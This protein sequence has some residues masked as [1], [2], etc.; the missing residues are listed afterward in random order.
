MHIPVT[1]ETIQKHSIITRLHTNIPVP[2][3]YNFY[4]CFSR[5][6]LLKIIARADDILWKSKACFIHYS[7]ST[8]SNILSNEIH[9]YSSFCI[10]HCALQEYLLFK[11]RESFEAFVRI[12]V[13]VLKSCLLRFG[14]GKMYSCV[15][16]I[17]INITKWTKCQIRAQKRYKVRCKNKFLL[18]YENASHPVHLLN[19]I[20]Q[21]SVFHYYNW[22]V[23]GQKML[24]RLPIVLISCCRVRVFRRPPPITRS[25]S[26]C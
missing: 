9:S 1:I 7:R 23:G 21:D 24:H 18:V 6:L 22:V 8:F 11:T 4:N 5:K 19:I 17:F 20:F 2:H 26:N 3:F 25:L 16:F 13:C 10:N 12:S 14:N 15:K